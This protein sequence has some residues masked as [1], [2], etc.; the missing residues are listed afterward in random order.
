MPPLSA[1]LFSLVPNISTI[2]THGFYR[3]YILYIDGLAIYGK[4]EPFA[5]Y[6]AIPGSIMAGYSLLTDIDCADDALLF[7][8]DASGWG[9]DL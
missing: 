9:A 7:N 4:I 8:G 5:S 6:R 1:S 2:F 3:I